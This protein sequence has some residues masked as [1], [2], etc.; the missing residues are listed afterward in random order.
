MRWLLRQFNYTRQLERRIHELELD[1]SAIESITGIQSEIIDEYREMETQ[2]TKLTLDEA[3]ELFSACVDYQRALMVVHA[4][5]PVQYRII[6]IMEKYGITIDRNTIADEVTPEE[7]KTVVEHLNAEAG[8]SKP[9]RFP[10]WKEANA[11]TD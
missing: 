4:P 1:V 10:S 9:D 7:L 2:L 5:D 11:N 8:G 6:P 3:H